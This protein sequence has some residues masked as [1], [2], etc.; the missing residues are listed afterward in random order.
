MVVFNGR[1]VTHR[2]LSISFF[3]LKRLPRE[4]QPSMHVASDCEN[5]W[6]AVKNA[7]INL[8]VLM[9]C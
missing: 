6:A 7:L 4:G 3:S 5:K 2:L 9:L 8:N 1:K